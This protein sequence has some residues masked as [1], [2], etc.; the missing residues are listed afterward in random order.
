MAAVIAAIYV[1]LALGD[2]RPRALG[3]EGGFA[4]AV[5]VA[6]G[7]GAFAVPPFLALAL[8]A[9]AG[10]DLLHHRS[11]AMIRT[12]TVPTWYPSYCMLSDVLAAGALLLLVRAW[13]D[14]RPLT[15]GMDLRR[16]A[17]I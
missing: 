16:S 8:F 12:K 17:G 13:S 2:G 5:A 1:G 3:V 6:A 7:I 4:T 9:H 15:S 11:V 10:W 14:E